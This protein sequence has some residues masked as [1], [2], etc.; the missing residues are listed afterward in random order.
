MSS[1]SDN[2]R[3]S[4]KV[5]RMV[6]C[7]GKFAFDTYALAM[8]VARR[9]RRRRGLRLGAYKCAACDLYH[10]GNQRRLPRLE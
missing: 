8:E 9:G 10:I 4:R 5:A 1:L 2:Q 7:A 3:R 6:S